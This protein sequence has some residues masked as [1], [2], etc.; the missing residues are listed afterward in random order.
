M[1]LATGNETQ[2]ELT[3]SLGNSGELVLHYK[4]RSLVPY[5]HSIFVELMDSEPND[6]QAPSTTI[7]IHDR[8]DAEVHA[9]EDTPG[10]LVEWSRD[11]NRSSCYR[12]HSDVDTKVLVIHVPSGVTAPTPTSTG[13]P[14]APGTSQT[15]LRVKVKKQGSTPF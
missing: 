12:T 9:W 3:Y 11:S 13:G 2:V 4:E 15:L 8:E 1:T 7:I 14:P 10:G 5:E 6:S